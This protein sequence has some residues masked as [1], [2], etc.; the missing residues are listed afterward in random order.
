MPILIVGLS[1]CK[2]VD[3]FLTFKLCRYIMNL[4]VIYVNSTNQSW[5]ILTLC[6]VLIL[7]SK[8][9]VPK[10]KLTGLHLN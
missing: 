9:F 4:G 5:H 2:L 6:L 7:I 8:S 1:M 3:V 10:T